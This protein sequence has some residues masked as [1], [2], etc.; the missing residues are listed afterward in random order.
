MA[1]VVGYGCMAAVIELER[2][3]YVH[4]V[5]ELEPRTKNQDRNKNIGWKHERG[6]RYSDAFKTHRYSYITLL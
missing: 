4:V 2:I 5:W 6:F 1:I 3:F